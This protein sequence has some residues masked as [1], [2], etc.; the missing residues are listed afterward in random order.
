MTDREALD[1]RILDLLRVNAEA[2]KVNLPP[3]LDIVS[4]FG[5]LIRRAHAHCGQR[6]VV[7]VDE[8]DKITHGLA[9]TVTDA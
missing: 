6:V 3:R 1:R 2:L 4:G 9:T 7:L 5:E 8:Y